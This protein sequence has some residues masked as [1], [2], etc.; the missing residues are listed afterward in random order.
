MATTRD[1]GPWLV[2]AVLTL[3]LGVLGFLQY[4]WTH[5]IGRAAAERLQAD[6]ERAAR[7]FAS[8][9]ERELGQAAFAFFTDQGPL[10]LDRR[11]ALVERLEEW[12]T[13]ENGG[14]V[15]GLL[16]A[17]RADHGRAMLEETHP[18]DDAFHE[19][20]WPAELQGLA[21]RLS[22]SPGAEP[23]GPGGFPIRPGA[24]IDKPLG[25]LLPVFGLPEGPRPDAM[26][27]RLSISGVVVVLLDEA[28]LRDRLLPR[29]AE[30]HF[31]P[32]ATSSFV[33]AILRRSDRSLFYASE[34][35]AA[36]S[37]KRGG[38]VEL[39]LPSRG[40]GPGPSPDMREPGP[41]PG[42][43]GP[44]PGRG[45]G[46][47]PEPRRPP[48]DDSPWLL[49]AR[50]RGGSFEA[51]VARVQRRNLATGFGVLA[52]LGAT[53]L[54]L[55]GSAQRARRLAR[56]QLE[57]VTGVTH[58][59]NTPL[60]A[61]RSAG[62]NL[63]AGIVTD[64]AQVR[65]YGDLIEKEGGRLTA[66]VAQVLD[67][68]GIESQS[69]AYAFEPLALGA[70]VDEVLRDHALVLQ[71]AGLKL[72]RD[73]PAELPPVRG[74]AA[75]LKRVIANLIANAAKFAG[76]GGSLSVRAARS[77]DGKRVVLRVE[78]R[79]PGIPREERERVFDSFY[80]GPAAERNRAPGS[81]LGLSLVRHVVRAHGGSARVEA[82]EGGGAALVVE[83]PAAS[84]E[85]PAA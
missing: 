19:V 85:E 31:G 50:H 76:S 60:A 47:G 62:Q 9:L 14:L 53:V 52:L 20:P 74:D 17:T 68:A 45:P 81:G 34:P 79:G 55:V 6:L 72:E 40:R 42:G 80:R 70:L 43:P 27:G 23:A 33:V 8:A 73:V 15:S 83:L 12:H 41:P 13:R 4:R 48:E 63:A 2:L 29:L 10:P 46:P 56:Q 38:D 39:Q 1:H 16:L 61:I 58:E 26:R 36:T 67:F 44:G 24:V 82:R 57:F 69:R 51:A 65:R 25:L 49:V 54:V 11:A 21:A 5:E 28:Y 32:A 18:G 37:G 78:D 3:L 22:A 64:A 75:A 30:A 84:A 7:R 66:L 59:L 71:Q 35:D 77:P